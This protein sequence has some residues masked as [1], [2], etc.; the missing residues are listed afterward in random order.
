M[1]RGKTEEVGGPVTPWIRGEGVN[2]CIAWDLKIYFNHTSKA[3]TPRENIPRNFCYS[4]NK[5]TNSLFWPE[6]F[7]LLSGD[8]KFLL[9]LKYNPSFCLLDHNYI[10]LLQDSD[11]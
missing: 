2:C 6:G 3:Q 4:W 5:N 1:G 8:E 10:C 7:C 11:L 9:Q